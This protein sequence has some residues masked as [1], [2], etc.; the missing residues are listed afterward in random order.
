MIKVKYVAD[1]KDVL[2]SGICGG[3]GKLS[4]DDPKMIQVQL[5]PGKYGCVFY[6]CDK[7]RR[8]LYEKI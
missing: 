6:L 7:C 2:R 4:S 5:L 1:V 3:C 8:E